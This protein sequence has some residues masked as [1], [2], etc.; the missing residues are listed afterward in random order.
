MCC[1][2]NFIKK[3][4]I[5]SHPPHTRASETETL[6]RGKDEAT[7]APGLLHSFHFLSQLCPIEVKMF[8]QKREEAAA[9]GVVT[10]DLETGGAQRWAFLPQSP[11]LTC[12]F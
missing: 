11:E 4:C 10:L 7:L 6:R 2:Q 5:G 1:P 3:V 12:H 9:L 8:F